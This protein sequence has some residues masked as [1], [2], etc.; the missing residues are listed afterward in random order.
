M[1]ADVPVS[2]NDAVERSP[3]V[4]DVV[5]KAL[6]ELAMAQHTHLPLPFAGVEGSLEGQDE[7]HASEGLSCTKRVCVKSNVG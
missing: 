2:L 5:E 1:V 3:S 7:L 4:H 6:H